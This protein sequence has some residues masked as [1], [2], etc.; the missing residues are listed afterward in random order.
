MNEKRKELLAL[1]WNEIKLSSSYYGSHE[2]YGEGEE[3]WWFMVAP[4][5]Y[6]DAAKWKGLKISH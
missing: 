1:G 5:I 6:Y 4:D 2:E 3:F